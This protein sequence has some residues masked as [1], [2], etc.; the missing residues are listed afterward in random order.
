MGGE[1]SSQVALPNTP[2]SPPPSPCCWGEFWKHARVVLEDLFELGDEM[3]KFLLCVMCE[4][5]QHS[6]DRLN[7]ISQ[8]NS[9]T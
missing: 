2:G 5:H 7:D 1:S 6:R 8:N 4:R 3:N 9:L